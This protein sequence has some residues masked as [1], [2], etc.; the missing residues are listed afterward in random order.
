[1]QKR[2]WRSFA[3]KNKLRYGIGKAFGAP[4]ITGSFDGYKIAVLTSEHATPDARGSRKLTAVEVALKSEMSFPGVVGSS[5]MVPLVQSLN[6]GGEIHPEHENWDVSYI[7]RSKNEAAMEGYL[8][9]ER[10]DVLTSLMKV[11]NFWVIFIFQEEGTLLRIDTT[12]PLQA[13]ERL[14]KLVKKLISAARILE[15]KKGE[16]DRLLSLKSKKK[17]KSRQETIAIP[18]GPEDEK[19]ELELE[20]DEDDE[21]DKS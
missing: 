4:E 21:S 10:L 5:G 12:D 16:E 19:I 20:E 2:S 17:V 18:E 3:A 15:L 6:F 13:P 1:M 8:S 7:A 14:E 9:K 11:K